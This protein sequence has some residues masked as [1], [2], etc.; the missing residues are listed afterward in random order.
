MSIPNHVTLDAMIG[1]QIGEIAALPAQI[2]AQLQ[3]EAGEEL[4]KAKAVVAWL[5]GAVALKYS[6]RAQ[7]VRLDAEKDFGTVRF[8]DDGVTIVADL[9]RKVEWDQHELAELIERIKADGEN[10]LEYIDVAFKVSERKYG[11]WPG[12]IRR[13]FEPARTVR[14]GAQRF[15]LIAE[16]GGLQ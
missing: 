9:P 2:L 3:R 5:D 8:S 6:D 11:A 15:E 13:A 7:A 1:M 16:I 12:H 4:R 10:P 14:A